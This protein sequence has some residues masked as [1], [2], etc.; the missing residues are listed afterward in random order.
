MN[1]A[2]D[3]DQKAF[4]AQ[5]RS[6]LRA[7]CTVS[8]LR[9]AFDHPRE[10]V[11]R[12][13]WSELAAM[14][15]IGLTA[16]EPCGGL[17]LGIVD[18]VGLL[19]EA[20]HAGL[21]EP[22]TET[23]GLVVPLL[24]DI[25]SAAPDGLGGS[26]RES[27]VARELTAAVANGD[28]I[29]TVAPLTSAP[30]GFAT[31]VWGDAAD[32][33]VAVAPE[34]V[35][36]ARADEV[37]IENVGSIDPTRRLAT[38]DTAAFS[39][40]V[41]DPSVASRSAVR[42]ERRAAVCSAAVLLGVADR[43][44]TLARDYAVERHQFGRPIGSFQAVKHLLAGAFVKLEMARPV[45]Y[46]AANSLDPSVIDGEAAARD[47]SMA[48]ALAS[49]A[50]AEAARVSLQVHGAIGYTWEHDLHLWMKRAWVLAAAWGDAPE[51][52][53]KLLASV[54]GTASTNGPA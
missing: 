23:T 11:D 47:A 1:F 46:W 39:P 36:F 4:R 2:F 12:S 29:A 22:I 28:V 25:A 24:A 5:L 41:S 21:P 50:A 37:E 32:V 19:E 45:V 52:Y 20:G 42:L 31:F 51:H 40:V 34:R 13:R 33:L 43:M 17:G 15:V 10:P 6:F 30:D 18:L 38:V 48:K 3:D 35:A 16:P 49:E 44:I 7:T 14:G 27:H 54:T 26:K 8:D 53:S 9:R